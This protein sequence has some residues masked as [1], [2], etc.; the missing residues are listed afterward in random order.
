[1]VREEIKVKQNP[2]KGITD[3][4]DD[5]RVINIFIK[6]A[7][8]WDELIKRRVLDETGNTATAVR[9]GVSFI[10]AD[11]V[12]RTFGFFTAGFQDLVKG[13]DS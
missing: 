4:R 5:I 13:R 3:D 6:G 10:H 7:Q 2:Y 8:T 11:Y 9:M 1:M 12:L